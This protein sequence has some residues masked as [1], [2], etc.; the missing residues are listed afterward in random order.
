MNLG[1]PTASMVPNTAGLS[2]FLYLG[3]HR[4]VLTGVGRILP[5]GSIWWSVASDEK[6]THHPSKGSGRDLGPSTLLNP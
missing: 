5:E 1:V 3:V 4:C 2:D 6:P